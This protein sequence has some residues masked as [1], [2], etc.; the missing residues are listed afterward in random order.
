MIYNILGHYLLLIYQQQVATNYFSQ[1][2]ADDN[3]PDDDLFIIKVPASLYLPAKDTDFEPISGSFEYK[4]KFYDRVKRKVEKDT[5]YIYCANNHQKQ[6]LATQI[7]DYVKSYVVD[8][9]TNTND[10]NKSQKLQKSFVK[11]Y[12]MVGAYHILS[13]YDQANG[14]KCV[15]SNSSFPAMPLI[16]IPYPPPQA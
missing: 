4:G 13:I 8:F 1:S 16:A 11:D 5:L 2:L 7:A 6:A 15:I 9:D 12:L 10:T 14:E 3:I